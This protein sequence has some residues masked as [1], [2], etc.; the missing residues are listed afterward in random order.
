MSEV[1]GFPVHLA[2][3]PEFL[4]EGTALEDSLNPDRIVIGS[5]DDYSSQKLKE[6][7]KPILDRGTPW[8]RSMCQPQSL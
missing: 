4:R 1:A 7:Y 2:W 3:N 6:V 8:L 5:W